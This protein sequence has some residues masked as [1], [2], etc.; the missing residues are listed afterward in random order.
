VIVFANNIYITPYGKGFEGDIVV[1]VFDEELYEGSNINNED[2][3][4]E[5]T[6]KS[7][8]IGEWEGIDVDYKLLF[9]ILKYSLKEIRETK[10]FYKNFFRVSLKFYHKY[11]NYTDIENVDK[12]IFNQNVTYFSETE[13]FFQ[14][15]FNPI[16][17]IRNLVNKYQTKEFD[18]S[19]TQ[20]LIMNF[21]QEYENKNNRNFSND[22]FVILQELPSELLPLKYSKLKYSKLKNSITLNNKDFFGFDRIREIKICLI[23]ESFDVVKITNENIKTRDIYSRPILEFYESEFRNIGNFVFG[24]IVGNWLLKWNKFGLVKPTLLNDE[25]YEFLKNSIFLSYKISKKKI[26]LDNFSQIH[27]FSKKLSSFCYNCNVNLING[28]KKDSYFFVT[29]FLKMFGIKKAKEKK[30]PAIIMKQF[31][32]NKNEYLKVN[33]D[34]EFLPSKK[35]CKQ[36]KIKHEKIS[37]KTHKELDIFVSKISDKMMKKF[38][39][40]EILLLTAIDRA[41]WMRYLSLI[42]TDEQDQ[43]KINKVKP[44][45]KNGEIKCPF[46]NYKKL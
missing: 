3:D 46:G 10:K 26:K 30:F 13:K 1:H 6:F 41:F 16:T 36:K 4:F 31:N 33:N 27:D 44:M 14:V 37:F 34:F 5:K 11:L 25:Q 24:I 43:I 23:E 9:S 12:D 15:Y 19:K 38:K 18:A 29:S 28:Q 2:F 35:F 20:K 17:M 21:I 7:K 39:K 8:Y 22:Y 40:E 32:K 45:S 42:S